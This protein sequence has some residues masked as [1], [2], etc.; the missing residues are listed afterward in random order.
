MYNFGNL[1]LAVSST[2]QC[3]HRRMHS[4]YADP[5]DWSYCSVILLCL[6]YAKE[7]SLFMLAFD[8]TTLKIVCIFLFH[9][10]IHCKRRCSK[11]SIPL[12]HIT[13]TTNTRGND[14]LN[15]FIIEGVLCGTTSRRYSHDHSA[16]STL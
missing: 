3:I 15:I 16:C 8:F 5:I 11:S 7:A 1:C 9:E 4:A 10:P 14:C 12:L 13:H 6:A 2:I